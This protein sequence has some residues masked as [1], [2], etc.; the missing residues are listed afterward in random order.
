LLRDGRVLVVGGAGNGGIAIA[1]AETYDRWTDSWISTGSLSTPRFYASADLLIDGKVLVAGGADGWSSGDILATVEVF[2]PINGTW[3]TIAPMTA[4]HA[5]HTST[6]LLDGRILIASGYNEEW[7][8]STDT[9]IYDP[10]LGYDEAWRPFII[11]SS[12]PIEGETLTLTGTGF[13]GYQFS[14]AAGGGTYSTPTNLPV[15]QIRGLDNGMIKWV[16]ASEFSK[17]SYIS[18]PLWG[19]Q[20]GPLLVT[21]FVN[22]IPS[23]A[24]LIHSGDMLLHL[25]IPAVM[26]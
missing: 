12:E 22:G 6:F 5:A 8:A 7:G 4:P 9:Q 18:S 13:R 10:G 2:D 11:S 3:S 17:S 26:R 21:V 1:E 15:V 19:L 23:K 16:R 24:R 14:E 20:K 25:Y